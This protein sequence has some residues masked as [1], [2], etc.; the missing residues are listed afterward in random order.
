MTIN[1]VAQE[2]SD[3]GY[4]SPGLRDEVYIQLCKQVSDNPRR[5]SLRRGWELLGEFYISIYH[6]CNQVKL[7]K[8]FREAK[9]KDTHT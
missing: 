5:E 1:S 7:Y 8:T 2:I 4:G 9:I 3:T 6:V